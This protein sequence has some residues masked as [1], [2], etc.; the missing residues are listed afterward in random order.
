MGTVRIVDRSGGH[1]LP[2]GDDGFE[3]MIERSIFIDKSL[4][5][6]DVLDGTTVNLF[7]R[8][9]R[10]GKTLALTMLKSFFETPPDGQS[11]AP[12]FEGLAIWDAGE[13]R[14]RGHQ[15]VYPVIYISFNDVK[16]RTWEEAYETLRGKMAFEYTRHSYLRTSDALTPDERAHYVRVCAKQAEGDDLFS[17]LRQ[18]MLYLY[19]HHGR[20]VVVLIDEYDAPVMAGHTYGY[21]DEIVSFLKGWMTGALKDGG[22]ALAFS[23]LTGVQR[24]SK[25]SIFSD[26]NNVLVSTPLNT[27]ADERFGFTDEE[28]LALATYLRST[29]GTIDELREWYDG[30]RFGEVDIYNPW[31]VLNYF[32]NGCTADYYWTNTSSNS[33]IG[34]AIRHV[35]ADE[36]Q[37]LYR[38]LEPGGT[39]IRPLDMSVVFPD[40]GVRPEAIWGMLYLAGYL[41]T[42]DTRLPN[43]QD[44]RRPLRIPNKEIYGLFAREISQR[45]AS[46]TTGYA[47][48]TDLHWALRQGNEAS[49]VRALSSIL[50][51]AASYF[52]LTSENS[53]HMMLFGL[54]FGMEGYQVPS[55]NRESGYGRYDIKLTP[56]LTQNVNGPQPV[57]LIEVKMLAQDVANEASIDIRLAA[58]AQEAVEQIDRQAYKASAETTPDGIMRVGIAFCGKRLAAACKSTREIR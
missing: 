27:L 56:D 13:G 48:V 22:A 58:R 14:Y 5:V 28:V 49:I 19:K 45:F 9:R 52:D 34:E 23:C 7:C 26:L 44:R 21:Y 33:V 29:S 25:E 24:I 8:P 47:D 30:Y 6:A 40:V 35:E 32:F 4:L 54:C 57:I 11:R 43:N 53:Y 55:S 50:L 15:G 16:R 12:L 17:S 41:T 20:R 38:L 46:P 39:I 3:R 10:F 1:R 42:E 18:L 36:M 31:S 51:T 37:D 2:I